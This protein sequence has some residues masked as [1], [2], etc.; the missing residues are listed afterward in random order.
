LSVL[1]LRIDRGCGLF[2]AVDLAIQLF[3]LTLRGARLRRR[4]LP[5]GRGPFLARQALALGGSLLDLGAVGRLTLRLGAFALGL[6][7]SLD[8]ERSHAAQ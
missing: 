7:L 3:R 6:L 1:L 8:S 5:D 4:P 2:G